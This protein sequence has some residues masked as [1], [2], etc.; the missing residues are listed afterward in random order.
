MLR[1]RLSART[2]LVAGSLA[3][4]ACAVA[5]HQ[6]PPG[7]TAP[8]DM[9]TA[10]DASTA[11]A[12]EAPSA[13]GVSLFSAA[14]TAGTTTVDWSPV[15]RISRVEYNNMVRDLLGDTTQPAN[16]FPPES[17][18][19]NGV[20]FLANTYTGV[21]TLIVQ[22][23]EQAAEALANAA[24]SDADALSSILPCQ[25]QD[26]ACAQQFIETWGNQAFRGQLDATVEA[27]LLQL[28]SETLAQFDFP[29]GIQAIITAVLE[30][31]RFL[32]VLE[33]GEPSE[34]GKVVPLTE[35]EIAARLALFLWRS[36]PDGALMAAAQSGQLA[37]V[38]EV[39]AQA[40]RM[41]ADKKASGAL[42]DFA[43]QWMQLQSTPALGKDMQFSVWNHDPKLGSELVDETL[44]DVSQEVLDGGTLTDLLTS[45]SS[46]V[47]PDL[48]SFYGIDA[49]ASAVGHGP[50]VT[51]DDPA[52]GTT[53][54]TKTSLPHRAGVLAER[55]RAGHAG[56]H[57]AAVVGAP[58]EARPRA[59]PLRR[60]PPPPGV[61]APAASVGDGGTT[62]AV[63]EAHFNKQPC[64]SCR[65]Y[66]DPIGLGFGFFDATGAY[67]PDDANGF[68][69][70]PP[71]RYPAIDAT[72][73]VVPMYKTEFSTT[74]NGATD[75]ATQLAGA[76]QTQQCFALQ[77]FRYAL[78]RIEDTDDACSAQAVLQAFTSSGLT[79]EKLFGR[80]RGQRRLPLSIPRDARERL[81]MTRRDLD[82]RRFLS[83]SERRPSRTRSC[84]ECRAMRPTA[85]RAPAAAAIR[86]TSCCCS[87]RAAPSGTGGA[88]RDR[89]PRTPRPPSRRPSCSGR[90]SRRS[91]R[92]G[93]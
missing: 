7:E 41:L 90:C 9:S 34:G 17:P 3:V 56:A 47:N 45:P 59:G 19:T 73:Q 88:R 15:R 46:Y 14:C 79:I 54:Y 78:S 30:S 66:V 25:T 80:D 38:A 32:Y 1:A 92:P 74:F 70:P 4:A 48:A 44:T 12:V 68:T 58:R 69:S 52:V 63:L 43:T 28:F 91:P 13:I 49:G 36:V 16:G 81:P 27:S 39:Q 29:T 82:R 85:A 64:V 8:G 60:L 65:R 51:V 83:S 10:D 11:P 50:S 18:L 23:Y 76:T 33:F 22:D 86:C 87:P 5:R 67:Q 21:S 31:P 75:L 37:T 55:E 71:G 61:P 89:R 77:E 2:S 26:A 42:D 6:V 24:V 62:R 72:G 93:R 53:T 57:H 40:T 35:Y 84:A 20:N